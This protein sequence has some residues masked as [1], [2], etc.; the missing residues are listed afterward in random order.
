MEE[1]LILSQKKR[2]MLKENPLISIVTLTWNTTEVTCDFLRSLN[3]QNTY[4]NLEVIV[5]DNGSREDP[6]AVFTAIY[7]DI[8]LI[9]NPKNLGFT[10]GN[11]VGIK[12]STCDYLFIVNNDTEFTPRVLE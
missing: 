5:V 12:A 9:R 10:G 1:N 3:E 2:N 7:P 8:K 4:K 6:T 11:N